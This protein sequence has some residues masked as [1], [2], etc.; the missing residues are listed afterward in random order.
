MLED[1]EKQFKEIS[2]KYKYWAQTKS[3][4]ENN[5]YEPQH[6]KTIRKFY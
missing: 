5:R 6:S 2:V 3:W 4:R 1:I